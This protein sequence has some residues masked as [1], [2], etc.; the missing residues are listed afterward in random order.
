MSRLK[1][2]VAGTRYCLFI[3]KKPIFLY[4]PTLEV[5]M[6]SLQEKTPF[7]NIKTVVTV[8]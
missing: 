2:T 1:K 8:K 7:I 6:Y 4:I 5:N 3:L